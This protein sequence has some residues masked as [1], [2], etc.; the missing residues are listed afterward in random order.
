M[1]HVGHALGEY[2]LVDQHVEAAIGNVDLDDVAVADRG[3]RTVVDSLRSNV[4]DAEA[5]RAAREPSVGDQRAVRSTPRSLECTSDGKHLPHTRSALRTLVAD[6]QHG[7]G[8]DLAGEDRVHRRV[9]T[10]EHP[11]RAFEGHLLLRESGDLHHAPLRR[12]GTG[13]HDDAGIGMDRVGEG[14]DD[15]TVGSG[16]VEQ[17]EVLA[18]GP[19]GDRHAFAVE[20][21]GIEQVL[22]HHGHT[23]DSVEVG[24]MER[25]AGLHVGDVRDVGAHAVEVGEREIDP[26]L[27]GDRKEVQHRVGRPTQGKGH[28]DGVLERLLGEDVTRPDVLLEQVHH[29]FAGGDRVLIAAPVDRR[30]TR[31]SRKRQPQGFA[32]GRHGVG[33]E[34]AG[35]AALRRT[36]VVLDERQFLVGQLAD[37]V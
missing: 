32:N 22:H 8:F 15:P 30:S 9:L 13:E 21:T 33:R 23:A 2:R 28:H 3:D 1:L 24:H 34:H 18:H 6:H 20:Q 19:A 26:C 16:R 5:P 11:G 35:T 4:T 29:R 31:T 12:Q 27:V 10:F 36:R 17:F 7:A 14:M 37:G 25:A